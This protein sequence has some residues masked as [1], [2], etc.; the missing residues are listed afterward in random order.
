MSI[1]KRIRNLSAEAWA[2]GFVRGGMH[3]VMESDHLDVDWV[4]MPKDRWFADPFVLDVTDDE[5]LLLVEDYAYE[6]EKGIISLLHINRETM[7]I[8]ARKVLLELPTHLS[9]PA[10]WR[11]DGH[12]YVYPENAKS[13]KLDMYEFDLKKEELKF[14]KTICEDVVWDSYITEAFGEPL[15]F[16]AAQNDYKLDLYRWN[17]N[18]ERFESWQKI[19]SGVPNMRMGGGVFLYNNS[20]Y[21]PAQN[22]KKTYGG[23]IDIKRID[24][25]NDVFYFETVKHI[26]SPNKRYPL[27]L[28][29]MNEYKGVAV[30]DVKGYR[31]GKLGALFARLL[32]L[33]KRL[34]NR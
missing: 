18:K 11:K 3:S 19:N 25:T 17:K 34:T 4:K 2:L 8:T 28:H 20:V 15:M 22:N 7:E 12:V 31:Y 23:A 16:T 1:Q 6:T 24:Y 13:G 26:E 29:T 21:L 5:I 33:K 14:V 32:N 30:I 9:F 27:G 10:I